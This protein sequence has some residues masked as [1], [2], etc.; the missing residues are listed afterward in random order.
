MIPDLT[1]DSIERAWGPNS[2][3]AVT[4]IRARNQR[5]PEW[6]WAACLQMVLGKFGIAKD[7][8]ELAGAGYGLDGPSASDASSPSIRYDHPVAV[9]RVAA[10]YAKNQVKCRFHDGPISYGAVQAELGSD[11]PVL[12]GIEWGPGC[13]A[14]KSCGGRRST[15]CWSSGLAMERWSSPRP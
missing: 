13:H 6:C 7:Q 2:R 3:G 12:V 10:E 5:A 8:W 9:A 4:G 11:R 15:G 1:S 14:A